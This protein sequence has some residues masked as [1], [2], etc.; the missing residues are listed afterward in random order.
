MEEARVWPL[1]G[2]VHQQAGGQLGEVPGR[3]WRR[4]S[5]L[6]MALTRSRKDSLSPRR[7]GK[8]AQA[9]REVRPASWAPRTPVTSGDVDAGV[10]EGGADAFGEVFEQ[11]RGLG[12]G[13]GAWVEPVDFV[14]HHQLDTCGD[15]GVADRVGDLG[16]G[17]ASG[18]G[19][20]EVAAANSVARVLAPAAGGPR[21]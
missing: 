9:M 14:D 13:G 19:D 2:R 18:D 11:V 1:T 16:L 12:A 6:S 7:A 4:S 8:A 10:D 5:A 21:T 15:V 20:A 3:W 17:H